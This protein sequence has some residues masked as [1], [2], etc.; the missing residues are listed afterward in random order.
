MLAAAWWL[1]EQQPE[2][3]PFCQSQQ[4]HPR[5]QEQQHRFSCRRP[6]NSLTLYSFSLFPFFPLPGAKRLFLFFLKM[7]LYHNYGFMEKG[8]NFKR[9]GRIANHSEN[10][11]LNTM[12]RPRPEPPTP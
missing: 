2:E 9:N 7:T 4:Q 11:R 8:Y 5:Q 10:L 6:Q 12:V 3:L 1:L